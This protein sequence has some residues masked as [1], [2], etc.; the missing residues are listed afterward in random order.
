MELRFDPENPIFV[1]VTT[2]DMLNEALEELEK[3]KVVGID[4]EG[5]SLDPYSSILLTIQIGT[6]EKTFIFDARELKLKEFPRFKEFL[7]NP[8]IIKIFHN[9][10]FDYK[11]IKQ[12]LGIQVCNLFDTMLTEALLNAGM[13]SG[14]YSL[15]ELALKYTKVD[16]KKLLESLLN[17]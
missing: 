11:H 6:P 17:I 5:T 9:G 4:I 16:L 8:K 13:S 3:L 15:K 1:H 2:E 12:N 10:K 7:E 14:Y